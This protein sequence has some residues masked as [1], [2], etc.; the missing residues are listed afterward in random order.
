MCKICGIGYAV[1]PAEVF[2]YFKDRESAALKLLPL[3]EKYQ[4]DDPIVLGIPRG[5][6]PMAKIISVGLGAELSA[7]L[8]HK[9]PHPENE[10]LAIGCIGISGKIYNLPYVKQ[11]LI[12]ESYIHA[13]GK[14]ILLELK[15]RQR[16][17]GLP[18][19]NLKNRTVIIVDDG[20][21]TGATTECAISE[22]RSAG[23]SQVILATPVATKEAVKKL[24]SVV[25]ELVVLAVPAEF[26]GVGQ[27]FYTFPQVT[28]EE[29]IELLHGDER[30]QLY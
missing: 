8:V 6:M 12:P 15:E 5:A 20:I 19:L 13:V 25:D 21:A 22:V 27:F 16:K 9:I 28:D 23:A 7:L 10:E 11:L 17:Y 24:K 30:E 1:S 2:M 29:V 26:Y 4:K 18:E 14:R 3:L